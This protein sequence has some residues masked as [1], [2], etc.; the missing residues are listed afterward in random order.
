[1]PSLLQYPSNFQI[2]LSSDIGTKLFV[3][4]MNNLI[5]VLQSKYPSNGFIKELSK[6]QS[7]YDLRFSFFDTNSDT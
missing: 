3:E 4:I 1:M 2:N 6:G 7:G 5:P